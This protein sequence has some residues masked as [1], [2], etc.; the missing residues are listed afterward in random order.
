MLD[1][2]GRHWTKVKIKTTL[3]D[4]GV[5]LHHERYHSSEQECEEHGHRLLVVPH[6]HQGVLPF[7]THG[8][9][10]ACNRD[11]TLQ[12]LLVCYV[13]SRSGIALYNKT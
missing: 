7:Q 2:I 4:C 3:T 8:S 1:A 6:L 12:M 5:R 13:Y 9:Q 10:R 11:D